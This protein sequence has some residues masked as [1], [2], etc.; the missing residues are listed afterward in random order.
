MSAFKKQMQR[1]YEEA[2]DYKAS[3]R[4]FDRLLRGTPPGIYLLLFFFF[5]RVRTGECSPARGCT[6]KTRGING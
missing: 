5:L 2:E 4:A 3:K 6:A 1:E